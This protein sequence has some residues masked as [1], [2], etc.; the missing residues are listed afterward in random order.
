MR[1]ERGN[2]TNLQNRRDEKVVP[3]GTTLIIKI[4][5]EMVY[6]KSA[7]PCCFINPG[8]ALINIAANSHFIACFP[9]SEE[10][11]FR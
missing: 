4:R 5:K 2:S 8:I 7:N 1:E 10:F 3:S 6:K 9:A 11:V